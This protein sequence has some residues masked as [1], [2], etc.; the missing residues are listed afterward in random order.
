MKN[1]RAIL[2]K[3]AA[4]LALLKKHYDVHPVWA[5]VEYR[6]Y[7]VI[8]SERR[9]SRVR[10]SVRDSIRDSIHPEGAERWFPA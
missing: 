8:G 2:M 7:N 1:V 10:T 4:T 6:W 9:A 5:R 3:K